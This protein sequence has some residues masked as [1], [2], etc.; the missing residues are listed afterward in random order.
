MADN[1]GTLM[2]GIGMGTA[3]IMIGFSITEFIKLTKIVRNL[4]EQREKENIA[5]LVK[6]DAIKKVREDMRAEVT[7]LKKGQAKY[8]DLE[9]E[10]DI[11]KKRQQEVV[12]YVKSER[13]TEDGIFRLRRKKVDLRTL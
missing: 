7:E 11:I 5:S 6:E 1:K 2:V 8:V 4:E 12:D 3:A 10:M 13:T 9:K